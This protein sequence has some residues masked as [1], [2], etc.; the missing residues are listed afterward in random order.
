[1]IWT[2]KRLREVIAAFEAENAD[3]ELQNAELQQI[4]V[5]LESEQAHLRAEN[6]KLI[7]LL[8]QMTKN[9]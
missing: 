7:G 5:C 2:R 1:M 3:Y 8:F 6:K 4:V 9:G